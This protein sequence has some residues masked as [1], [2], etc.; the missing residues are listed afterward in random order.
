[1]A[2]SPWIMQTVTLVHR[3]QFVVSQPTLLQGHHFG[4]FQGLSARFEGG[5]ILPS[6]E[7]GNPS[8]SYGWYSRHFLVPKRDGTLHLI[9][10]LRALN[11]HLRL[12][13]KNAQEPLAITANWLVVGEFRGKAVHTSMLLSRIQSPGF[14]RNQKYSCRIP[15]QRILFLGLKP[16]L[17]RMCLGSVSAQPNFT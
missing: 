9:P 15:S 4:C 6:R 7:L 17:T 13:T 5:N 12:Q 3:L 16:R 10:D 1:M 14:I 2:V 8:N 11:K